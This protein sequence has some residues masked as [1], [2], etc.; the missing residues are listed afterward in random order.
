MSQRLVIKLIPIQIML[1]CV[2]AGWTAFSAVQALIKNGPGL[3][4]VALAVQPQQGQAPVVDPAPAAAG[5]LSTVFTP[6][7][8][9]WQDKIVAW[10]AAFNLDPNLAATVMQ[11][12]SCG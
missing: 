11:I 12:E 9:H 6:E 10:S 2:I 3:S 1:L 5:T 4:S 8:L 7:V